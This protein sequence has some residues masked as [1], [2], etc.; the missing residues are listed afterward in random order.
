MDYVSPKEVA[1]SMMAAAISKSSLQIKD[2][3]IR[4]SMSGALLG[5]SVTLANLAASQTKLSMAG[6]L[7]FPVGFVIIIILGMELVTG[8]FS[9]IP[10][11][12]FEHKITARVMLSNLFWVFTGNLIGSL[13]FA[14]LF[15]SASSE[16]GTMTALGPIDKML[17]AAAER[18]TIGYASHGAA[19][20]L[21]AFVKA[22]LCNWMVC[23]GVVMAMTSKSTSGKI[24][25]AS[26]PI[27][28]FFAL[29]YEHAVVNMFV[30]PAGML[31][32]AHVSIADWWLDNQLIVTLGNIVGVL[33]FTGM[34]I[35]YTHGKPE[36][37]TIQT[38]LNLNS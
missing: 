24:I 31:F 16:T 5:I 6:A 11:A 10:L 30:I 33:L 27:F 25:A 4:G 15:W 2:L 8:S 29:G 18:K 34:A 7:V 38:P 37:E 32:G 12:W 9:L 14:F 19:G 1:G 23:M 3:L 21:T 35:Y 13:L 28:I 17:V 26:I 36:Q 22:V 20:M